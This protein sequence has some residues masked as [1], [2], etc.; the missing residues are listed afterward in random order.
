MIFCKKMITDEVQIK[1]NN[2]NIFPSRS[3][4]FVGFE[5]DPKLNWR[6]HVEVKCLATQRVI[7]NLKYC[8]TRTWGLNTDTLLT[9]FKSIIV[10]KLLYGVSVWSHC[11]KKKWCINKLWNTQYQ[12][13]KCI[14]RSH[15]T[16]HRES[17]LIIS[18]LLPI[19]LIAFEFAAL[20]F[21]LYKNRLFSIFS[22]KA[23]GLTLFESEMNNI[24]VVVSR[25]FRSS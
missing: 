16:A 24:S 3:T 12:I 15:K 7:H 13:L 25:N 6:T 17:L 23:F 1:I 22:A 11:L 18:N 10:P 9:L 19:D 21:F 20:C 14:T 8:L 5:V 4:K 2:V